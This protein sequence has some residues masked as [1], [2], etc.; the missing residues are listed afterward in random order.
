MAPSRRPCRCP[1][2]RQGS[3]GRGGARHDSCQPISEI[4][5]PANADPRQ[6]T[7]ALPAPCHGSAGAPI[8]LTL[9]CSAADNL[10]NGHLS[11]PH[12]SPAVP[13]PPLL[14]SRHSRCAAPILRHLFSAPPSPKMD[15]TYSWACESFGCSCTCWTARRPSRS[16]GCGSPLRRGAHH[17]AGHCRHQAR[18]TVGPE[19]EGRCR[20]A[21]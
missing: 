11:P 9:R 5:N 6:G 17:V 14:A 4:L 2:P 13:R 1:S 7:D 8:R 15:G 21:P 18:G 16:C 3:A 20:L 12:D 19:R 10:R